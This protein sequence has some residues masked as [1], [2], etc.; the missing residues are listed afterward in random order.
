MCRLGHL[1]QATHYQPRSWRPT[2]TP[3]IGRLLHR[4]QAANYRPRK[5]RHLSPEDLEAAREKR[6]LQVQELAKQGLTQRAI[7][8]Q[9]DCDQSTVHRDLENV[10]L[11]AGASSNTFPTE[12]QKV[13]ALIESGVPERVAAEVVGVG[14]LR[15]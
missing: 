7:A 5:R 4:K 14:Q 11:D 13:E 12:D 15:P 1:P 2:A 3:I 6:R 9:L 10:L 8:E